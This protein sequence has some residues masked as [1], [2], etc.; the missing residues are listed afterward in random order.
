MLLVEV[1]IGITTM[2]SSLTLDNQVELHL[3][4][5]IK[6]STREKTLHTYT[7]SLAE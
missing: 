1:E 7:R 2:E 6:A 4:V 3:Q 5:Y